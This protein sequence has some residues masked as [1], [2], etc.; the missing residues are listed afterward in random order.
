MAEM[1]TAN[2]GVSEVQAASNAPIPSSYLGNYRFLSEQI[3][4]PVRRE[5]G[6]ALRITSAYRRGDQKAHGQGKAL[7]FQCWVPDD[8]KLL[9]MWKWLGT[10]KTHAFGQC[11][12]EP[13]AKDQNFAHI[14]VSMPGYNDATGQVLYE[15]SEGEYE[16]AYLPSSPYTFTNYEIPT[17][18][19]VIAE[20]GAPDN[21]AA[22]LAIGASIVVLLLYYFT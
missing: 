5:F 20:A 15:K 12:Y 11:I 8:K 21:R 22:L 14:H 6:V 16:L 18:D 2:F 4:Q 7:D 1:F 19:A 10:H 13:P 17:L 3:L 9:E